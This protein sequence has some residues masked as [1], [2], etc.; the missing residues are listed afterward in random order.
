MGVT[1][2]Y[3]VHLSRHIFRVDWMGIT[4]WSPSVA[5]GCHSRRSRPGAAHWKHCPAQPRAR[6]SASL[7]TRELADWMRCDRNGNQE[8]W[9][10]SETGWTIKFG[11]LKKFKSWIAKSKAQQK[12]AKTLFMLCVSSKQGHV[13]CQLTRW[14]KVT[15]SWKGLDA[16]PHCPVDILQYVLLEILLIVITPASTNCSPKPPNMII[17][18]PP[19]KKYQQEG[20]DNPN[21]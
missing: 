18:T 21:P 2:S 11:K 14:I 9:K 3:Y 17:I 4:I 19:K 8:V 12:H 10:F 16:Y 5:P 1:I 7:I 13:T 15:A 6:R 20:Y